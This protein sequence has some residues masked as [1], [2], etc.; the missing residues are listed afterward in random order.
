[1]IEKSLIILS[2]LFSTLGVQ[3]YVD[4]YDQAIAKIETGNTSK[5]IASTS[6]EQ[7]GFPELLPVPHVAPFS[8]HPEILSK[9]YYLA[10]LDSGNVILRSNDKD[11]VPIAS[12]T[13]IMT[14]ALAL[15]TYKLD[16]VVTVSSVA[17]NQIGADTFLRPNE[18]ITVGE[19]LYCLLI[20]SGNDAA[21][22]LAEHM[23]GGNGIDKFVEAMN[24]KAKEL[25]MD[26]TNYK[27]PA[28]L[29]VSGYS[30]AEDL[31]IITK[32]AM[33]HELFTQITSTVKYVAT[34]IDQNIYHQLDNSNRLV[35]DYQY[36]GAIG[37]KTGYMPEAGHCLVS[38]VKRDGHTLIGVVLSTFADT[39][40]ASA[41]ESKKLQDWGWSNITWE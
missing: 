3:G 29:D 21:Y 5:V 30:S 18:K 23:S 33:R 41:D 11:R 14:A 27:D 22:A 37:I 12:T 20:K 34:N 19:L 16:D 32:Y 13:K 10:D 8:I 1:M 35:A 36:Q 4:K 28:G 31:F 7:I 24:K 26:N 38:A 6:I 39:P 40:S 25:G 9:H 2:L 17:S 15:D